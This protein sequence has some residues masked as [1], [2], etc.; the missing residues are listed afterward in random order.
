MLEKDFVWNPSTDAYQINAYFKSIA[1][2]LV[3]SCDKIIDTVA[4]L[5]DNLANI[6]TET[7]IDKEA[8]CKIDDFYISLTFI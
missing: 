3:I 6:V 8:A 1:D 2:E 7:F 5:F 4:K